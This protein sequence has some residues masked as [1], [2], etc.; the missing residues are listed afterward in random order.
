MQLELAEDINHYYIEVPTRNGVQRLR[1]DI[2]QQ[3]PLSVQAEIKRWNA[4]RMGMSE[5]FAPSVPATLEP[6]VINE[7]P[8]SQTPTKLGPTGI[9]SPEWLNMLMTTPQDQT[10]EVPTVTGGAPGNE[11]FSLNIEPDPKPWYARPEVLLPIIGG[12][13]LITYLATRK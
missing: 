5:E 6:L 9:T 4:S 1:K 7:V 11:K 3:M 10:Q 8:T 2:F 12:G 13:V